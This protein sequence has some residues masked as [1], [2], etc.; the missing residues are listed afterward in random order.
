MNK[1][2]KAAKWYYNHGFGVIPIIPD[3]KKPYIKWESYQK[4]TPTLHEIE[5]WWGKWDSAMVGL[6]TGE[7][8]GLT[9][10]DIDWYKI[11]D[12]LDIEQKFPPV[13][14]PTATSPQGGEHRYFKYHPDC[15][16]RADILPG[17]DIRNDGGYIIAPPSM[18]GRGEYIWKDRLK[19]SD[20]SL[21]SVPNAYL[22]N[23]PTTVTTQ[24][25]L[26][27]LGVEGLNFNEGA[28]DQTLFHIANSLVKGGM[29]EGNIEELLTLIN[30]KICNPPLPK[31]EVVSKINSA[32]KR[33]ENRDLGLTASIRDNIRQHRGIITTT[34]VQ[35]MTTATTRE[36][37]NKINSILC[38]LEKE[39]LITKTRVRA[40]EYR[41]IDSDSDPVHISN[42]KA[43][44]TVDIALPF[45]L[46]K[47]LHIVKGNMI[48]VI[49]VTN[50]GKSAILLDMIRMNMG[51]H[52]CTYFSSEMSAATVKNRVNLYNGN[53]N[54]DFNIV[55]DWPQNVDVLKPNEFNFIDWLE[56]E[57]AWRIP[58]RLSD[59]QRKIEDGIAVVALQKNPYQKTAWGGPQ[60]LNKSSLA[61]LLDFEDE[62]LPNTGVQ[63]TIVK[64]KAPKEVNPYMWSMTYHTN[65]GINLIQ[66][67]D[68]GQKVKEI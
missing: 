10:F 42:V 44:D 6:V 30:E 3:E 9:V 46:E 29:Y 5:D 66:D 33:D 20:I 16:Q 63:M 37:K 48:L 12:K 60:T 1:L 67:C 28:R 39:G 51:K 4:K 31:H 65:N 8:Y 38:R 35:Q 57:E 27:T 14:T 58:A 17:V 41:I 13:A 7:Y 24:T 64:C 55:E 43:E 36:E 68:W 15:P 61:L 59:I 25:T 45:G 32:F 47:Y 34:F 62:D 49:G 52:K 11:E 21:R 22:K 2:L 19:I 23:I 53:A 50:S 18:N 40:G 54:W 56:S 26:T